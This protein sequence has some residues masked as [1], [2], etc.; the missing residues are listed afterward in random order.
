MTSDHFR[1]TQGTVFVHSTRPFRLW[2]RYWLLALLGLQHQERNEELPGAFPRIALL[3][4]GAACDQDLG[5]ST[6]SATVS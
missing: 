6:I 5:A 3:K 4:D 1:Q 2:F